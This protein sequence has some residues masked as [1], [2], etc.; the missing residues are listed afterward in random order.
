MKQYKGF[1][2]PPVDRIRK[3]QVFYCEEA[4]CDYKK[5]I[6]QCNTCIFEYNDHRTLKPFKD[7]V[8][9]FP[10]IQDIA[11]ELQEASSEQLGFSG[12]VQTELIRVLK[13]YGYED[14]FLKGD[15]NGSHNKTS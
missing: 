3:L 4:M 2:V 10:D 5:N 1:D 6:E 7:W 15:I 11:F 9:E 8:N 13:K 14:P 12:I